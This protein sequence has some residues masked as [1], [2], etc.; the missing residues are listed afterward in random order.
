MSQSAIL[1]IDIDDFYLDSKNISMQRLVDRENTHLSC[2]S[3]HVFSDIKTEVLLIFVV[4]FY[5]FFFQ[6]I[7]KPSFNTQKL[8][9]QNQY[10]STQKVTSNSVKTS[11]KCLIKLN[12]HLCSY[13]TKLKNMIHT[14]RFQY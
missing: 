10:H 13:H 1:R 14:F 3:T 11:S 5:S 4:L 12:T 8:K 7:K 9:I 6:Y 2:R